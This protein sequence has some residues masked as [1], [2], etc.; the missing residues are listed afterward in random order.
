M[1]LHSKT[2]SFLLFLSMG[3][4]LFIGQSVVLGARVAGQ[5]G[6]T[7]TSPK[8]TQETKEPAKGKTLPAAASQGEQIRD[9]GKPVQEKEGPEEGTAD[10]EQK[11]ATRYVTI[12][13]DDVDI[14]LF[15]KFISDLTGKNFVVDKGVKGTVTIISP[16]KITVEEAYKVFE[17]VLEVHG[18]T[19]VPAG[20][21]IKIVPAVE[22]RSKDIETRLREEARTPED[23]VV[24][25]LIPL[26]YADP[27]ELKKLF[28][29]LIS[30]SSVMVSYSPTGMLIVT[31]VLSNINRLFRII[32]EIDVQGIGG[33]IAVVPLVHA[34]AS[35]LAKTLNELFQKKAQKVKRGAAAEPLI[36]I[37]PDE[38][39]NVLILFASED[40]TSK[41][42]QLI[43]LLDKETPR[44]EG[45]V[46][47]VYL[48]NANAEDL[49]KVMMA[50][51][52]KDTKATEKGKTPLVS[53]EVQIVA[54]KATNSL[55]ITAKKD[56]FLVLED[57]IRKL[58]IP[59]RMVYLE[60]LIMEV[61]ADKDFEL[62]VEWRFAEQ[63]G[64]HKGGVIVPF[65][66]SG[67]TGDAGDFINM[68]VVSETIP[69]PK[70]FSVGVIGAGIKI[71]GFVFPTLGAVLRAYQ[72]DSD[73][74]IISTPQILTTDNEEAQIKVGENVPYLTRREKP[75]EGTVTGTE[76]A[77]YEYKDVGV[78]LK[79][80]PQINQERFV[81]LKIFQE[82]VK[83]KKGTEEF[84]PT[85]LKRTAETTVIVKDTNT[86]VIGGII[87]DTI[88]KTLYQVPCLGGI[89]G[90]GW[91]FKSSGSS[92]NRTNLFVFLTPHIIENPQE[93]N[94]IYEEKKEQ[95]DKVGGGVI[96]M[97]E[98]PK[99]K[100]E[101][102]GPAK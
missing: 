19:T 89:P 63:T 34:T 51:P 11:Q 97:Y 84:T 101:D 14:T 29:P 17:S 16:T 61:N 80:T 28:A 22:A 87:G 82:V 74:H 57:V 24:T 27:D 94:K 54:D 20:N 4:W 21:I 86:V 60:V 13:F 46:R 33:E 59:R 79:I 69:F 67:G 70:G 6:V 75:T 52:T 64:S 1:R 3:L 98:R 102:Q 26:K 42:K 47:V 36:K 90:L 15:I 92:F 95:I 96:K 41:I 62:G 39:T 25:Q 65:S 35:V 73:V 12:D 8:S 44:G 58:D 50:I 38:R 56:D 23:K 49:S 30:K 93:A 78:T 10:D 40:D 18:Y 45:D 99:A 71:G 81:R 32:G 55:V 68:P 37:V 9:E 91:F 7:A 48:Q 5:K 76:Y 83:L 2:A 53:K 72:K 31:D 77:N 66:G 88:E 100:N 85:T 43:K